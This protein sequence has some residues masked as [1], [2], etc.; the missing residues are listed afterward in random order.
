L[1]A[2]NI[3]WLD[4]VS[5][6]TSSQAN[7][8][9]GERIFSATSREF[10]GGTSGNWANNGNH[11]VIGGNAGRNGGSDSSIKIVSSGAGNQTTNFESLSTTYYK[12]LVS[13]T[14]YTVEFWAKLGQAGINVSIGFGAS[15]QSQLFT[16]LSTS[17]WTKCVFNL[18]AG[19]N[20]AGQS[21]R[22]W[23]SAT[24]ATGVLID[25]VSITEAFDATVVAWVKRN[26]NPSADE[27]II[28]KFN[29]T[30]AGFLTAVKNADD[31]FLGT[32]RDDTNVVTVNG[33]TT[34]ITDNAY[35]LVVATITRTGNLQLYVD[36]GVD[37]GSGSVAAI[38]K[39]ITANAVVIGADAAPSGYLNG[40]VGACEVL[41]G[42][43]WSQQD[44]VD[45]FNSMKAV[46][47]L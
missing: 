2:G 41:R 46:Y 3:L 15:G 18:V 14:K 12:A 22:L 19:A 17:V 34:A 42:K 35:H 27:R 25:D 10:E 37:N 31:K 30:Q 44:C 29:S 11:S 6:T 40:Q 7:L 13:G 33:N 32:L 9:G 5:L 43:I 26:G 21:L 16:G 39:M 23:L 36:A 45:Y 47:G 4:E 1:T 20:D 24:D 38:G 28:S 8:N